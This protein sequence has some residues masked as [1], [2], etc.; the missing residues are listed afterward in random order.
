MVK[1]GTSSTTTARKGKDTQV[2]PTMCTQQKLSSE[3]APFFFSF[4]F[5]LT[6]KKR[7]IVRDSLFSRE[8][9]RGRPFLCAVA[10]QETAYCDYYSIRRRWTWGE[11][12]TSPGFVD[13]FVCHSL[14]RGDGSSFPYLFWKEAAL[15]PG[16]LCPCQFAGHN[17]ALRISGQFSWL[18]RQELSFSSSSPLLFEGRMAEIWTKVKSSEWRLDS[19]CCYSVLDFVF[20]SVWTGWRKFAFCLN[21]LWSVLRCVFTRY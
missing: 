3:I 14:K 15:T 11:A 13:P 20:T 17:Y 19:C 8:R 6:T 18:F 12:W 5:L 9:G 1:L 16:W 7:W 21:D 10:W 2:L 4:C